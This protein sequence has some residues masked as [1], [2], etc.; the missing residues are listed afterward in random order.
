MGQGSCEKHQHHKDNAELRGAWG[1]VTVLAVG[2][3]TRSPGGVAQLG[4]AHGHGVRD[5]QVGEERMGHHVCA[6]HQ[7]G[8]Q[9]QRDRITSPHTSLCSSTAPDRT[10]SMVPPTTAREGSTK[11]RG[12]GLQGFYSSHNKQA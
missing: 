7:A 4:S 8:R 5:G 12:E 11:G 1:G 6:G 10:G 9:E 3:L 2:P